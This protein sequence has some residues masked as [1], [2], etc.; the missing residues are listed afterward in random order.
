MRKT[1]L[2]LAS[3]MACSVFGQQKGNLILPDEETYGY[4]N[5]HM[6]DHGQWTAYALSEDGLHFHDLLCGDS[7][8]SPMEMAGIEGGTRD[9]YLC[10]T[11]D[12]K[13]YLMVTTDMNN[14]MT[15]RLNKPN[16]WSNFGIDL[17]K[18]D[19]LINWTSVTFDF[20]KWQ[21]TVTR[22]WAPQVIW[23][24]DY[25]WA[26]GHKG[27]YMIYYS[28]LDLEREKYDRMYY[29]Y[30]D[31]DFT[32]IT[33][34]QLL[35]DWGYATIDADIN[36][37]EADGMY[38]MMI[39][40]EGGTPGIF[41]TSAAKLTGPWPEPDDSHFVSFE[42]KKMCEGASAFQLKGGQWQIGYVEYS[43]HPHRYRLCDADAT[44]SRFT[45]P[46]DIEGINGPQHGSFLRITEEEYKRL[47]AWSDAQ[48]SAH[49]APSVNNPVFAGLYADPEVL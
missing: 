43:S 44:L 11:H 2:A 37:I 46:R 18:S 40:K 27:G 39:K 10:R 19:D 28:M 47:Q 4:L 1:F 42:G 21:P 49:L 25:E 35:F 8:F 41:T 22:V 48:E 29:S 3:L 17:L 7:I 33:E 32:T 13:G 14:K 45:N 38:H 5:C 23:D 12:G 30:A 31:E 34:P 15:K 9:A 36:W 16:E 6:S 26:D 20:R 24:G